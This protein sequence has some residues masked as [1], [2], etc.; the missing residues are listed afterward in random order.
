MSLQLDINGKCFSISTAG[1]IKVLSGDAEKATYMGL[2]DRIKDLF[3]SDKKHDALNEL[4]NLI[5]TNHSEDDSKFSKSVVS[6]LKLKEMALPAEQDLF[7]ISE[8]ED[9]ISFAIGT[10]VICEQVAD[11]LS[12]D[13]QAFNAIYATAKL[14]DRVEIAKELVDTLM[15]RR[16]EEISKC[17]E[18]LQPEKTIKTHQ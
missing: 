17:R 9:R 7:Q 14:N 10:T 15:A 13:D 16:S 12:A 3:R 1:M 5:Y 6:F 11:E 4:C 2:W 8:V 18:G